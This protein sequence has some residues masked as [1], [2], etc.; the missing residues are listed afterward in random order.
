M[1]TA[2]TWVTSVYRE[3][4]MKNR[5]VTDSIKTTVGRTLQ[6]DNSSNHYKSNRRDAV[7]RIFKDAIIAQYQYKS[8]E[9]TIRRPLLTDRLRRECRTSEQR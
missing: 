2:R 9:R 4:M 1:Y 7:R 6:S 3:T 8:T 5:I